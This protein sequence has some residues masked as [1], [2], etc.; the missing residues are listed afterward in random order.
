[1]SILSGTGLAWIGNLF[2]GSSKPSSVSA[3][4]NDISQAGWKQRQKAATGTGFYNHMSRVASGAR[5]A[6]APRVAARAAQGAN[7]GLWGNLGAGSAA[8]S[9][10]AAQR[11]QAAIARANQLRAQARG[12]APQARTF[13][14]DQDPMF[15][16]YK[17]QI[18][19]MNAWT[20]DDLRDTET[21]ARAGAAWARQDLDFQGGLQ[22]EQLNNSYEGRGLF[23]SGLRARDIGRQRL[24]EG[25]EASQIE[26]GAA[27]TIADANKQAG[28]E[29][30]LR[31]GDLALR[32]QQS[33]RSQAENYQRFL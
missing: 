33:S 10:S 4:R 23:N 22:R 13:A 12:L 14:P 5:A 25:R 16:T 7:S 2:G 32:A 3:S 29:R 6:A 8:S 17:A 1:M 21:R 19:Q 31:A 18:D 28:R 26:A 27:S 11:A 30:T 15:R 20:A 24:V 9:A